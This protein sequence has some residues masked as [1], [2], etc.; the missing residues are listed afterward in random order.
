MIR[1]KPLANVDYSNV[2]RRKTGDEACFEDEEHYW[3]CFDIDEYP[4]P[5]HNVEQALAAVFKNLPETFKDASFYYQFSASQG[6]KKDTINVHLW[7]WLSE[8]YSSGAVKRWIQNYNRKLFNNDI[9]SG[10][11]ARKRFIDES[12]YQEVQPHYTSLP[13][14]VNMDDP[15]S[16]RSGIVKQ[17]KDA[18]DLPPMPEQPRITLDTETGEIDDTGQTGEPIGYINFLREIGGAQGYREPMRSAI[19]SYV[20]AV[21]PEDRDYDV[22]KQSIRSALQDS[23]LPKDNPEKYRLYSSDKHL[24]AIIDWV[25][26]QNDRR[27]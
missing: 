18:V 8:K 15:I 16:N 6:I 4:E 1:G 24:N 5:F 20:A 13:A 25:E 2:V 12:L 23:G 14:F 10:R 22:M 27:E 11:K 3:C 17:S 21:E 9:L 19:C 26:E 7:F